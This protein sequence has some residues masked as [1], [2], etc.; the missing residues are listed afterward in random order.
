MNDLTDKMLPITQEKFDKMFAGTS[1]TIVNGKWGWDHLPPTLLGKATNL[2]RKLRD[3]YN[4]ALEKYDVLVMPTMV[5]LAPKL[6]PPD[7]S[8]RDFMINS[9]GVSLNSSAFNLVS[10]FPHSYPYSE[11]ESMFTIL[12]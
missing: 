6:P 4:A 10:S 3:E 1:N 12:L 9:V 11:G 2:I 5:M 8:I 7:A